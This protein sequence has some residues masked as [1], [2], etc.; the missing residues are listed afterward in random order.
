MGAVT[1]EKMKGEKMFQG[2]WVELRVEEGTV[3]ARKELHN[4]LVCYQGNCLPISGSEPEKAR[5][6]TWAGQPTTTRQIGSC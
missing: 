3:T 5:S 4:G 2:D 6:T 1:E